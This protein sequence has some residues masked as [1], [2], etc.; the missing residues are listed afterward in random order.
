M[1]ACRSLCRNNG[2]VTG[3]KLVGYHCTFVRDKSQDDSEQV[4]DQ[5]VCGW[6]KYGMLLHSIQFH[7]D[8]AGSLGF[9]CR[10]VPHRSLH[11]SDVSGGE[12]SHQRG[13]WGR[14]VSNALHTDLLCAVSQ[15]CVSHQLPKRFGS[16]YN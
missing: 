2:A 16:K 14:Q 1:R 15:I 9:R 13:N 8:N 11:A 10:D 6:I 12:H 4:P 5:P 3:R 7:Q